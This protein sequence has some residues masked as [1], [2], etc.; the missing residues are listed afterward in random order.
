M[1]E[2]IPETM[3][4]AADDLAALCSAL[5]D[6]TI[7]VAEQARLEDRLRCDRAA[8]D[9][10]RDFMQMESIL[11][12][13]LINPA[14][15]DGDEKGLGRGPRGSAAWRRA[16]AWLLPLVAVAA[17]AGAMALIPMMRQ[18]A[19]PGGGA[20]PWR[21]ARLIDATGAEWAGGARIDVGEAIAD[22]PL[23]LVA[24]SAQLRF[25]SG[26]VVTL[27]APSEIEVLGGNRL[28]LRNGSII[29]FVPP[30]A[31]GFTVVSPTGE[32][33]DLG[34]EFSVSVDARGQTDVYVIDG[35][36]DVAKGHAD[37]ANPVRMTQGFGTRLASTAGAPTLTQ[38]PLVIDDF[39][40][41]G[42]LRWRDVDAGRTSA[43]VA[44]E[45]SMPVEYRV[46]VA[47]AKGW[48]R[49][50]LDH[51]FSA[52]SGRCSAISFKVSLPPDSLSVVNRWLACVIDG[53]AG[54]PP[55]AYEPRAALAVLISPDFQA[56]VRIDGAA[57]RQTRVFARSEDAIGPYQVFMTIDDTPAAWQRY[58][59]TV[60]SVTING[61][62][63][64]APRPITLAKQ[65]RIGLQTFCAATSQGRGRAL[66]DDFSVSTSADEERRSE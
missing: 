58:G 2:T 44:G 9:A 40:G 19:N 57:V 26:A 41:T 5:V 51:D 45:L 15:H 3:P 54:E 6:G 61:Q 53:G 64:M 24:G 35:E 46:D 11:A 60:A 23:R 25:E 38:S 66:V 50:V 65:P 1:P 62:E 31:K 4:T 30:V 21:H 8:R 36:V 34:T 37:R 55:M 48:T 12:W 56:G 13:E 16:A 17:T 14:A 27:N 29:P 39:I 43:V 47:D 49:L 28:F 42:V 63:V 22:G 10:F 18:T 59:S 20:R 7:T 32:V 33:I 52:I